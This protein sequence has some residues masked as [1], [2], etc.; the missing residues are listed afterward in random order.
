MSPKI[1][2]LAEH[3]ADRFGLAAV[4]VGAGVAVSV[5]LANC[6]CLQAFL[7]GRGL[8]ITWLHV[9]RT[10]R[11]YGF[12]KALMGAVC[13]WAVRTGTPIYLWAKPF[14][15]PVT[16]SPFGLAA[17]YAREFGFRPIGERRRRNEHHR[18]R[19]VLP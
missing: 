17:W 16:R 14:K 4:E 2:S 15:G 8:E 18:V 19:M 10:L 6:Y 9:H 13:E 12:G 5:E 7:S 1:K 11:G 3:M